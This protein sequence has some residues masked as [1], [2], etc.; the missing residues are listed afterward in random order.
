MD[1]SGLTPNSLD[2]P[3]FGKVTHGNMAFIHTYFT[4]EIATLVV[5]TFTYEILQKCSNSTSWI[6]V[7]ITAV[8]YKI[9]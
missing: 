2:N 5:D 7:V 3:T 8:Q 9:N 6:N 4:K 1:T